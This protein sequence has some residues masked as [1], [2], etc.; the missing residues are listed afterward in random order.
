MITIDVEFYDK[1]TRLIADE[2]RLDVPGE[3]LFK[4]AEKENPIE[5]ENISYINSR[6]FDPSEELIAY[7]IEKHPETAEKFEKYLVDWI[8]RHGLGEGY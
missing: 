1:K 4:I 7:V 3:M 2:I 6:P 5:R 8:G